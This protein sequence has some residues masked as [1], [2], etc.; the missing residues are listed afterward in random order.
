MTEMLQAEASSAAT[1]QRSATAGTAPTAG[2][3]RDGRPSRTRYRRRPATRRDR[4][5]DR[6]RPATRGGHH[7]TTAEP[8]AEPGPDP[9]DIPGT[10]AGTGQ[11][12]AA[13][14]LERLRD[15]AAR[16]PVLVLPYG[17][18]D[19]VAMVRAG[20]TGEVTTAVQHGQRWRSGCSAP[21]GRLDPP[22][23]PS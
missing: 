18:P 17:D 10:V 19:V 20:L 15:V 8:A 5:A 23:P 2:A 4:T 12:A 1:A 7:R 21:A 13:S 14:F 11:A 3:G 6:H 9:S 16:Y 22:T